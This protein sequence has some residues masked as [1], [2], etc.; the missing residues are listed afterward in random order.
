MRKGI[1]VRR[2]VR[3]FELWSVF[4]V[5]L[6]FHLCCYLV[7][8]GATVVLWTI[9]DRLG[10]VRRLET[11]FVDLGW[12]K[13]TL[14]GSLLFRTL[15]TGGLLVVAIAV[16]G[17]VLLAFF[18]N[19][20]SGIVGG[21]VVSVLEEAPADAGGARS[22]AQV[23]SARAGRIGAKTAAAAASPGKGGRRPKRSSAP[24]PG[25]EAHADA[26]VA[27]KRPRA[28]AATDG[29]ARRAE[30]SRAWGAAPAVTD[31]NWLVDPDDGSDGID[32]I[33]GAAADPGDW[34]KA[35][36]PERGRRER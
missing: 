33:D 32:G 23:A 2:V 29:R 28:A 15:L 8:V 10:T 11:F 27:T 3:R 6:I 7:T 20:V 4:K 12:E 21:L 30:P 36:T 18:Y 13:F 35:I 31:D 14:E 22:R 9:A 17:T 16:L 25:L 1:K 5:G 24:A 19:C 34:T 26:T